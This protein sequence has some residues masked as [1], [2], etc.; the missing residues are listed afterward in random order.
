LDALLDALKT[1]QLGGGPADGAG[2]A[3]FQFRHRRIQ[4]Y[5][6]PRHVLKHPSRV[7]PQRLLTDERWRETAVTLLQTGAPGDRAM[8]FDTA[9]RLLRER[10]IMLKR[11][12]P[13]LAGLIDA[14][15]ADLPALQRYGAAPSQEFP[16]PP[17]SLHLLG[18][19]QT[20][21][22]KLSDADDA[23]GLRGLCDALLIAAVA[24]GS[25]LDERLALE[26]AGAG[27]AVRLSLLVRW[28]FASG[29]KWLAEASYRH[30]PRGCRDSM[31]TS[32]SLSEAFCSVV[33]ER[34]DWGP[35]PARPRLTCVGSIPATDCSTVTGC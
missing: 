25:L 33:G 9:E 6:A 12:H 28:G 8:L 29:S 2:T 21:L 30:K 13:A 19:L 5:F 34:T 27:S 35:I 22:P 11:N 18:V 26:L 23:A 17:D 16:W 31:S 24:T 14:P 4:E 10:L 7:A 1:V 15:P 32:R 20:V 3:G